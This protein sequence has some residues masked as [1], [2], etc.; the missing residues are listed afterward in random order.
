MKTPE[1]RRGP[2][3]IDDTVIM[4]NPGTPHAWHSSELIAMGAQSH[5]VGDR[6]ATNGSKSMTFLIWPHHAAAGS[7]PSNFR[8]CRSNQ[9][10]Y[11]WSWLMLV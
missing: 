1:A 10:R 4:E 11:S 7:L 9:S 3:P 8:S 6:A 2:P 5:V